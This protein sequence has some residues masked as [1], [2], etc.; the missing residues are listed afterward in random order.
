MHFDVTND[1]YVGIRLDEGVI[2][3]K[4]HYRPYHA[5]GQAGGVTEA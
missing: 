5:R 1:V 3:R 2:F 4:T